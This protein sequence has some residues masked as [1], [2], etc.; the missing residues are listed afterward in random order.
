MLR[1]EMKEFLI[2]WPKDKSNDPKVQEKRKIYAKRNP[3]QKYKRAVKY[4]NDAIEDLGFLLGNLPTKYLEK[5]NFE[6]ALYTQSLS[7]IKEKEPSV[8]LKE[9]LEEIKVGI[10]YINDIAI[11]GGSLKKLLVPRYNEIRAIIELAEE[12]ST[13]EAK[14]ISKRIREKK[15]LRST[16]SMYHNVY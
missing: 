16:N 4:A 1:K 15:A 8:R 7:K 6:K 10:D 12:I 11:G 14:R 9:V 13:S 3:A 2:Y 5:V